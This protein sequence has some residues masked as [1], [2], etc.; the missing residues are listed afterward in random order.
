MTK[1][2]YVHTDE[3]DAPEVLI[4]GEPVTEQPPTGCDCEEFIARGAHSVRC[5]WWNI[6][7]PV[8]RDR[9]GGYADF[10]D[11]MTTGIGR[12]DPRL[13]AVKADAGWMARFLSIGTLAA[14]L[15]SLYTVAIWA[16]QLAYEASP[17]AWLAGLRLFLVLFGLLLAVVVALAAVRYNLR[18]HSSAGGR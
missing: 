14:A 4:T 16:V 8:S 2:D 1:P 6:H 7:E 10:A 15:I 11:A 13:L 5:S 18:R 12:R 3:D 17:S 9:D